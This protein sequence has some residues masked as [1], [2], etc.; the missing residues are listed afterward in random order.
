MEAFWGTLQDETARQR[1]SSGRNHTGRC[2]ERLESAFSLLPSAILSSCEPELQEL[3]RQI[4]IM[5]AH[6]RSEWESQHRALQGRLQV[7]EEE[8]RSAR[9][10][11]E[12]KHKEVGMFRQQLLEAQ[13]EKQELVSKYEEQL[14]RVRE[15]LSKLKRSYEK[16]QRR[17]LKEAREGAR[18][19]E[20]DRTELSRLNGKIEEFR[21]KSAEWEQQRL[22]YQRQVA[23]LEAQRKTLA[24]QYQLMQESAAYHSQV[25]GRQQEQSELA[26][27][28][29]VQRLRSQLERA[30]D[31][32]HAQEM[33]LERFSLLWEELGDS[34]RELQV[35]SEEKTELKAT[36]N[37]QDEFV[38]SSGLQQ[39]QLRAELGRLSEAL[40]AK[41]HL[42]RSLESCLQKQGMSGGLAPLRQDLEQVLI[43]LSATRACEGHLKAEVALLQESLEKMRI[44]SEGLKEELYG[45]QQE[46]QRMEEEHNHCVGENKKLR[47]ELQ[48]ALQTHRGE[49]EGM[50]KEVSK[51]TGELHQRDITIATLSGSASS[52][53]RQL[54]AEVERTEH[55]AAELKVAQVQL[56]TLKM[57]NKH[58][59]EILERMESRTSKKTE[60]SLSALRDGYVSSLD[61][62]EQQNLQL[63]KDLAEVGARLDTSMQAWQDKYER[64]LEQSQ[65][66]L[67]Q[68]GAQ[69]QRKV[70]EMQMKHMQELQDLKTKM[71]ETSMHYEKEI[72]NLK[73]RLQEANLKAFPSLPDG[74]SLANKS[75]SPTSSSSQSLKGDQEKSTCPSTAHSRNEDSSSDTASVKSLGSVEHKEFTPLDP[76]PASPVSSVATRFLEDENKRS[77]DLLKRLD[78][79]IQDMREDTTKTVK[80]YLEKEA[81]SSSG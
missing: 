25:S 30:Q 78:A 55:R 19:R 34:R 81:G 52:I 29:E 50:K 23:A 48:R 13:N 68:L 42:I 33:E 11:L 17:Q 20:E 54:R 46:L 45:K 65:N 14:Q 1:G 44:Q 56:E 47:D 74:Q 12:H 18:S 10:A 76:L 2:V 77:Q 70:Q 57:E 75:N 35:L 39:K 53:E 41:E 6:K 15:E 36:L 26:I 71:Q 21:Q 4:D 22:Q 16:L 61:S 9:D 66:K 67:T 62:L 5:V 8:L 38:R 69:E 79:H 63:R 72:E 24:E 3:M 80:K 32:L 51:L 31:R 73:H 64:A 59:T 37:T 7:R 28:S 60:G 49:M 27:Q 43:Q 58:L 40:Q